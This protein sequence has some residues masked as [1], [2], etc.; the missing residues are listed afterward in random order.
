MS[1]ATVTHNADLSMDDLLRD[2][3]IIVCCGSGGVGKTTAAAALGLRA[4]DLGRR[5]IVITIDP[6]KRLAQSL[7]LGELG[8]EPQRVE[9]TA[10]G[11]T[12][13]RGELWAM[14]LDMKR[15]FDDMVR[16]MTSPERAKQIFA[17]PIYEH[18]SST[19]SG[20]QE[21]MA[22]EKLWELHEEGRWEL[23]I[24]DTPPTRSALDFL[25]APRRITDFLEGR[26]LKV[27]LWP[28]MKA[29]KGGLKLLNMGTRTV[30][31]AVTRVTGSDLFSD[32]AAF[33]Q[34]F[35][36]MYEGFKTRSARVRELLGARRTAFI[37]VTSP[38]EA[39][40]QEAR[41]FVQRLAAERMPL[42][43]I[44]VNRIHTVESIAGLEDPMG[45]AARA[46]DG[47][48]AASLRAYAGWRAVSVRE[49]H[50]LAGSLGGLEGAPI[51]KVPDLEGDVSD[52]PALREVGTL[53]AL[54]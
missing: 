15:T 52:V 24:I 31:K 21:Y 47:V 46:G 26:F 43:G 23:I 7:G 16:E 36:G 2:K 18:V 32:V 54:A 5:V 50:L 13:P 35:E 53:L 39:S 4:A 27:F 51:W 44:I 12:P 29:G 41:Y 30:L 38:T 14:M 1:D 40:L 48:L 17:N 42:G 45:M 25:D 11:K 28:Y 9:A 20:T 8:N 37:V 22:M 33:F 6:A 34:S 10:F 49:E 3:H 19:L